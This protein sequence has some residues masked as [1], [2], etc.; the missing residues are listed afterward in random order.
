MINLDMQSKWFKYIYN[1]NK[2]LEKGVNYVGEIQ[3][4]C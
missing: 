1:T 3:V 4:Y 2:Y